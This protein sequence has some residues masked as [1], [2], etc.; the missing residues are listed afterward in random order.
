MVYRAGLLGSLGHNHVV[1]HHN[2]DGEI[3]VQ[4]SGDA[5]V[6]LSIAVE[7]FV[8]DD[9]SLRELEGDDFPGAVDVSDIEGTR[10]NMLGSKLLAA[11]KFPQIVIRAD[12]P[13]DTA[14]AVEATAEVTVRGNTYPLQ[15]P[16]GLA[17]TDDSFVAS[18]DFTVHHKELGLKP[19][20]AALGALKVD[21]QLRIKFE[22]HGTALRSD[23]L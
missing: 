9:T 1:S 4:G 20:K 18:G 6:V 14:G 10:K 2:I 13:L 23:A 17:W 12:V 15:I 3:A 22:F 19:F 21:E 8:V 7:D 5:E 16:L 11:Q